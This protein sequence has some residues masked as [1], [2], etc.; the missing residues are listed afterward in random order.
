MTA[1]YHGLPETVFRPIL[2]ESA[3]WD[4]EWQ[5]EGLQAML[6]GYTNQAQNPIVVVVGVGG[7]SSFPLGR[8]QIHAS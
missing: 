8:G 7:G 2:F 1:S 4:G 6:G 5:E 3:R